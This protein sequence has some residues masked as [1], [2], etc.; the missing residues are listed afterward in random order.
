MCGFFGA[1]NMS[2]AVSEWLGPRL[3]VPRKI[4]H[5]RGPDEMGYFSDE[6]F[7]TIFLRLSIVDVKGGHQPMFSHSE[8]SLI[9][10]N[11]EIYNYRKLRHELESKGHVF[12]TTSDAEVLVN[13]FEEKDLD[14]LSE[15]E[16]MFAFA[17]WQPE[18]RRLV[19]VRDV[20]GIKP[21]YYTERDGGIIFSSELKALRPCLGKAS[22]NVALLPSW[23]TF[24]AACGEDTLLQFC[25]RVNPGGYLVF[26]NGVMVHKGSFSP[27]VPDQPL[28]DINGDNSDLDQFF[29]L[30]N[31]S[32]DLALYTEVPY[33]F[34]LSGGIDTGLLLSL[35]KNRD[36][37]DF[38][39]FTS[40]SDADE[41]VELESI[42][43]SRGLFPGQHHSVYLK[44]EQFY[45]CWEDL[46]FSLDE[47]MGD[48]GFFAQ[49][50]TNRKIHEEHCKISF[51]GHGIDE[52]FGGY[53]R[54]LFCVIREC[55]SMPDLGLSMLPDEDLVRMFRLLSPY[56]NL[57]KKAGAC[58][59]H[60][61]LFSFFL[62]FM[63]RDHTSAVAL[64]KPG[65]KFTLKE[66]VKDF[67]E[68][69]QGDLIGC[70]DWSLINHFEATVT[71]PSLL[72][73]EDRA[74]MR[75]SVEARVPY[76]NYRTLAFSLRYAL[77][78]KIKQGRTKSFV[79]NAFDKYL[80]SHLVHQVHKVGRPVPI[81]Q[82]LLADANQIRLKELLGNKS[83]LSHLFHPD[84]LKSLERDNNPFDRRLWGITLLELWMKTFNVD[85]A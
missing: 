37:H 74:S 27:A 14:G 53:A 83:R 22:L 85:V 7:Q 35:A 40:F 18:N 69:F 8:K 48:A 44:P 59:R 11:G 72:H 39:T 62:E 31:T 13:F 51:T 60:S 58:T 70:N 36:L 63:I 64:R 82:W 43:E 80:P 10:F 67:T 52:Y 84:Y 26:R 73:M 75:W 6:V 32:V 42:Q 66:I 50:M 33:G 54:Y 57:H 30:I 19:L 38:L 23:L 25:F 17:I 20:N 41:K 12:R 45:E 4:L 49:Y 65:P 28:V 68:R 78:A 55:F 61:S 2:D 1:V 46:A 56:R 21:L 24:Q 34:H 79:R 47:P 81:N 5:N 16:G 9:V 29:N 77:S 76:V 15:L 71:L 3:E